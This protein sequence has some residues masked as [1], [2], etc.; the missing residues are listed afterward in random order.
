MPC[1][2]RK[3]W[4]ALS[5]A[6]IP[7]IAGPVIVHWRSMVVPGRK[8]RPSEAYW[9]GPVLKTATTAA[10]S[11]TSARSTPIQ[12]GKAAR[13]SNVSLS[14][15]HVCQSDNTVD[16]NFI[17]DRHPGLDNVWLVGGGSYHAFKMGPVAGDYIA[18]RLV[19][20]DRNPELAAT[21]KIKAET[22]SEGA[23]SPAAP[24]L[25]E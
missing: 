18:Q 6:A 4:K 15:A 22:F 3:S 19:G 7:G 5:N 11:R 10:M 25:V 17:I 24:D 21:F 9:S 20:S 2:C 13:S 12:Q 14:C 23:P 1:C 8:K 16:G